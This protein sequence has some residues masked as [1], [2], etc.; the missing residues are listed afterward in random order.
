M[1]I[2]VALKCFL[3]DLSKIVAVFGKLPV[4]ELRTETKVLISL[5]SDPVPGTK[6]SAEKDD[7]L[8]S[9]FIVTDYPYAFYHF[10]SH[11]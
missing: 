1:K 8:L 11:L 3:V 4:F 5:T 2:Q 6:T 9:V 7:M 10:L